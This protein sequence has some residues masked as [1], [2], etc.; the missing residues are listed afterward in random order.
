MRLRL[1]HEGPARSRSSS[2][3]T[4][5]EPANLRGA[6]K[7]GITWER[8]GLFKL[9]SALLTTAGPGLEKESVLPRAPCKHSGA[10]QEACGQAPGDKG[11]WEG[12]KADLEAMKG[13]RGTLTPGTWQSGQGQG[14]QVG[15]GE[16]GAEGGGPDGAI[17]PMA[18]LHT[19]APLQGPAL[20]RA[21]VFQRAGRR[22]GALQGQGRRGRE[23]RGLS[24]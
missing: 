11:K 19:G 7:R 3:L 17:Q 9:P 2:A 6:L 12:V 24:N 5:F 22:R 23:T 4:G 16:H 20:P 21:L 8:R 18:R 14:L 13:H 10:L 15:P 1:W